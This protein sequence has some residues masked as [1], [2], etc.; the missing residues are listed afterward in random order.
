ML[1]PSIFGFARLIHCK[2][3]FWFLPFE[4]MQREQQQQVSL[5]SLWCTLLYL[6]SQDYLQS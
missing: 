3:V 5:P 2:C 6:Y 1:Q 4:Q